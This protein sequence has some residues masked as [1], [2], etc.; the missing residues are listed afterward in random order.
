MSELPFVIA[1]VKIRVWF[2]EAIRIYAHCFSIRSKLMHCIFDVSFNQPLHLHFEKC[3]PRPFAAFKRTH[4]F[5][6]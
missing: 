2:F 3:V 5:N 4:K 6:L 1:Y